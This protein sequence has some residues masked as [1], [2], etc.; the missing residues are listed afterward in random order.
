M[1]LA[2]AKN[3]TNFSFDMNITVKCPE[4]ACHLLTSR[5][6]YLSAFYDL[7]FGKQGNR[8]HLVRSSYKNILFQFQHVLIEVRHEHS[9]LNDTIFFKF[10]FG[11][12]LCN[13][14]SNFACILKNFSVI[15][16]QE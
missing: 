4:A 2:K 14:G 5:H 16:H 10:S 7:F 11:F 8:L 1:Q 3:K 6:F 15:E 9:I 13:L 12:C